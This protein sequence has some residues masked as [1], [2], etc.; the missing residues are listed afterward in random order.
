M[1]VK[2]D[3]NKRAKGGTGA[4]QTKLDYINGKTEIDESGKEVQ[5]VGYNKKSYD[6]II[7]SV[8]K[9]YREKLQDFMQE[10]ITEIEKL[11]SITNRTA[12]Q[13]RRLEELQ[14]KY[15]VST[16][17]T[18]SVNHLLKQLLFFETGINF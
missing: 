1:P 10:R 17:G 12:E 2:K 4:F 14:E 13:E 6:R 11:E 7:F 16:R 9:G 3:P 5:V 18:P 8:P 15:T